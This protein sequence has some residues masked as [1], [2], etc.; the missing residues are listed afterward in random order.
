MEVEKV[1]MKDFACFLE[2]YGDDAFS[3]Q[4]LTALFVGVK[5]DKERIGFF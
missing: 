2:I 5:V 1:Q 3:F 4:S